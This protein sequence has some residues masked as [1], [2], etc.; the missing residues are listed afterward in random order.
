MNPLLVPE[1]PTGQDSLISHELGHQWFS[2]LV[3][4]KDWGNIWLNEGF[5]ASVHG[6]FVVGELFSEGPSGAHM[7]A[8]DQRAR[9]VRAA[10]FVGQANCAA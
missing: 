10:K 8:L 7:Q 3:T 9:V 6:N 1:Y 5:F 2:D 4:C